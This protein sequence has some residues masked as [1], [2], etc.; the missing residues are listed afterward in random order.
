M[1]DAPVVIIGAGPVGLA[2]AAHLAER[3]MPFMVLEAGSN[4]AENV[5]R[6]GHVRVFSPWRYIIDQAA[7][8]LLTKHGWT[9]PD[10]DTLPTGKEIITH[11]LA[12]LADILAPHIQTQSRVIGI[13]RQGLDKVKT[14]DRAE[15]PF[16]VTVQGSAGYRQI[17]ASAVIDAS[18]TYGTPNPIGA[19]GYPAL[20]E[21][22]HAD[23]IYYGIPDI[24]GADRARY[25]DRR[26][27]VVG[28][29]HSAFNALLDLV[30]LRAQHPQTE[31]LWVLRRKT[32]G[33]IFGG[34]EEDALPSRGAL[35][36]RLYQAIQTDAID[37]KMGFSVMSVESQNDGII[38]KSDEDSTPIV[39]EII[40]TTGLRPD[41]TML[42]ELRVELDPILEAPPALAPL[43]DPNIHSCGT[44]PP[45]GVNELQHPEPNFYIIGMKSY[46]RAPTFLML[47]G[48]EQARSVVAALAGDWEAAQRVELTLPETGVCCTVPAPDLSEKFGDLIM[49]NSSAASE[50]AQGRCC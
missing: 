17:I 13:A 22:E 4:I 35:G 14:A 33:N 37:V 18:G 39:D 40:A 23:K 43:I 16:V 11:Y 7:E 20:G 36:Q 2:A 50:Q 47:T 19:N 3:Q 48:Y 8:R 26:V 45:H 15:R 21:R 24:L 29:G 46:G 12:P 10:L 9:P 41:L 42:R 49:L 34:G 1:S 28:S 5:R 44:V 6:W 25:A 27:V 32:F 38:L 30:A 31:I